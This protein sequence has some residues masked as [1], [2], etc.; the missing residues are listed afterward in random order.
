MDTN[1]VAPVTLRN[2]QGA[3][4]AGMQQHPATKNQSSLAWIQDQSPGYKI[5][6]QKE[7]KITSH[8]EAAHMLILERSVF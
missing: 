1:L 3:S 2:D 4:N 7:L 6:K 8:I 5:W